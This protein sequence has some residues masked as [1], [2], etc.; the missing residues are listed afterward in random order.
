MNSAQ[1]VAVRG[2]RDVNGPLG[3]SIHAAHIKSFPRLRRA[4]AISTIPE[5]FEVRL[6]DRYLEIQDI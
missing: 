6:Q 1:Q 4:V 3:E 2:P 5:G